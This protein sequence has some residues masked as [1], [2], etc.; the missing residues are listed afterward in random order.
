MSWKPDP[1]SKAIDALQQPCSHLYPY[2]FPPFSLIGRILSK[3]LREEGSE[4]KYCDTIMAKSAMVHHLVVWMVSGKLWQ[5]KA[6]Q[7]KLQTLSQTP[8]ERAHYLVTNQPGISGLSGWCGEKQV[9]PFRCPLTFVL[10]FL[11]DLFEKK[12]R[13]TFIWD[14]EQVLNYLK[15]LPGNE[16]ILA[17][18]PTSCGTVT[19]FDFAHLSRPH[20]WHWQDVP[21]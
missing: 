18:R 9:E 8:D 11:A 21:H 15:T 20:C 4:N 14:V 2:A 13:Y 5:Q 6:Y 17:N 16:D 3:V 7:E 19:H 12:P 10:D 1:T